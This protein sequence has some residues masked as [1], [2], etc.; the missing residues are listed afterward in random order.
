M[1]A[2]PNL[3]LVFMIHVHLCTALTCLTWLPVETQL[4]EQGCTNAQPSTREWA[5]QAPRQHHRRQS[6][7][8]AD[9]QLVTYIVW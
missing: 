8:D 9:E 5:R 7:A 3:V 4:E 1:N 6:P 2:G